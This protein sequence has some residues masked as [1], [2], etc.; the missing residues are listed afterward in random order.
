MKKGEIYEGVI[1]RVVFPNKGYVQVGD[2]T[3]IVKNG[4]PGQKVRFRIN[5]KKNGRC[6]AQLLEVLE[7]SPLETQDALCS[8]FPACGGCMYRTMDYEAQLEMKK[9]Q[10]KGAFFIT[11]EFANLFPDLL[12]R[13]KNEGHY[14]GS[15]SY[16]HLLYAAWENPDSLLVTKQEF[17]DDIK[18]S[19]ESLAQHDIAKSDAPYFI[20]PFEWYNSTVAS[21]AKELGLQVVNFTPGTGSSKDY[22]TPSMG[23]KYCSSKK[24]WNDIM[25]CEK[26]D[27]NGLNGHILMVHMGTD[28]ERTDKFYNRL[29]DLIKTLKKK[30]YN[31][32]SLE[33]MVGLNMK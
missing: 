12:K 32:V 4:I 15:H 31:F 3:V 18:R 29:P 21:W 6:E 23:A 8:L 10:V 14:V 16:G 20:P 2:D 30:G 24:L 1:D 5:K 27:P 28:P 25:K 9:N 7:K 13:M 33:E 22:T 26:T 19:F 11:G 17:V